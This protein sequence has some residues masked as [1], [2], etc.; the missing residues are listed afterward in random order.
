MCYNPNC[1]CCGLKNLCLA[2]RLNCLDTDELD[3]LVITKPSIY[4]NEYLYQAG[5]V[6]KS[7]F[8]VKAGMLKVYSLGENGQEIIQGFYLPGDVLGLDALANQGNYFNAIALDVASVCEIPFNKLTQLTKEIPNLNLQLLNIM[9]Q[10]IVNCRSYSSLLI[11]K[12]AE[13]KLALFI[14]HM[15]LKFKAIGY[16]HNRFILNILHKDV[17][18]YLSLTPETVSRALTKFSQ[19]KVVN[20]TKKEINIFDEKM[21]KKMAGEDDLY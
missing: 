14:F 16:Q 8:A 11:H 9:S 17:A 7:F 15:S 5:E 20:W 2:N 12:T 19:K 1:S 4:K 21:L 18:N 10:E 13:Q 3:K 6:L